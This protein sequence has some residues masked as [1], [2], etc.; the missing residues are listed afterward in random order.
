MI[1]LDF[2]SLYPSIMMAFKICYTTLV[3]PELNDVVPD[4][5]CNI[6]EFDQEEIDGKAEDE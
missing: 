2:A 5:D 3:P 1:C 4:E 6:I